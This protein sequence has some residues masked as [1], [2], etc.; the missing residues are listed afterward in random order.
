MRKL[1]IVL[2]TRRVGTSEEN[3]TEEVEMLAMFATVQLLSHMKEV[4]IS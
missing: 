2:I 4:S 3:F 1:E